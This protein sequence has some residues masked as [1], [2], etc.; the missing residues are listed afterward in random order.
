M[1][2]TKVK[3][4]CHFKYLCYRL[5]LDYHHIVGI[6]KRESIDLLKNGDF[7]ENSGSL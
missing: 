1:M 2:S 4:N 7:N 3:H 5:S 6:S